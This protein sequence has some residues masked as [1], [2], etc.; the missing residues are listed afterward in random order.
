MSFAPTTLFSHYECFMALQ[1]ALERHFPVRHRRT[2]T[3]YLS[4][5]PLTNTSLYAFLFSS[6]CH[7]DSDSPIGHNYDYG[8]QRRVKRW[9]HHVRCPDW[10]STFAKDL[11]LPM[12]RSFHVLGVNCVFWPICFSIYFINYKFPKNN[13]LGTVFFYVMLSL[14]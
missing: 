2:W 11:I 13:S 12:Q 1:S 9:H 3:W 8:R 5:L 6:D 14:F 10:H 4:P 7:L